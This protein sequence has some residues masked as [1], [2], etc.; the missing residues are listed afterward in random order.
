MVEATENDGGRK[1]E[2]TIAVLVCKKAET[3]NVV[4]V[5]VVQL[6]SNTHQVVTRLLF[7]NGLNVFISSCTNNVDGYKTRLIGAVKGVTVSRLESND[8]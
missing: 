2:E 7:R 5:V 3:C 1:V 8:G 6:H 4:V